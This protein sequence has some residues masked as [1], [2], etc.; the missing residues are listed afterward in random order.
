[1]KTT[2]IVLLTFFVLT[3]IEVISLFLGNNLIGNTA[4]L[5]LIPLIFVYY[6]LKTKK[7]NG[8]FTS[9]LFMS[10]V[11]ET[12]NVFDVFNRNM[13]S[14][15]LPFFIAN[16]LFLILGIQDLN[17]FKYKKLDFL[18]IIF[19][20]VFIS[21]LYISVINLLTEDFKNFII[22]FSIYGFVLAL[23]AIISPI[24]IIL[25]N[26]SYDLYYMFVISC[27]IIS[28]I[29][30][31]LN[32]L[33]FKIDSIVLFDYIFQALSYFF[34]VKYILA[35]ENYENKKIKQKLISH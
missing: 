8:L 7:L 18:S 28:D 20:V 13:Y 34:L 19:G 17:K 2:S 30:Y 21:Y 27:F 23:A 4:K 33:Y 10:Y 3:I 32:R 29:S 9:I 25:K 5:C 6:L 15:M 14:I 11:G 16:V 26:R 24:N 22:P 31:V 12:L 35:R 1:M